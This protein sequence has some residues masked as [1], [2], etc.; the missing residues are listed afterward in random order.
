MGHSASTVSIRHKQVRMSLTTSGVR[1][2]GV[3]IE[4]EKRV[5]V[6]VSRSHYRGSEAIRMHTEGL[7][8]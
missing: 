2:V 6:G 7:R 5:R 8:L 1:R 3:R 4:M